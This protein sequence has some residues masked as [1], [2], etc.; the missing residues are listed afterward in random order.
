M[1]LLTVINGS[2]DVATPLAIMSRVRGARL[3][4]AALGGVIGF[5]SSMMVASLIFVLAMGFLYYGSAAWAE[6]RTRLPSALF[7]LVVLMAVGSV[8][9]ASLLGAHSALSRYR[10]TRFE[11]HDDIWPF[12]RE[13][14]LVPLDLRSGLLLSFLFVRTLFAAALG[15]VCINL[16]A[17][18]IFTGFTSYTSFWLALTDPNRGLS[19]TQGAVALFLGIA[20]A[21]SFFPFF[22]WRF[23]R[24]IVKLTDGEITALFGRGKVS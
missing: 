22:Y 16:F 20:S 17:L 6:A 21:V 15:L 13:G 10:F 7:A 11:R 23:L 19:F 8:G 9:A 18:G 2:C 3:L 12:G 1:R 14:R 5:T 4:L 24:N